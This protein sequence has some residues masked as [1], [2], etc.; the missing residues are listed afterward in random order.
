M[1]P[2]T[3]KTKICELKQAQN[4]KELGKIFQHWDFC[5]QKKKLD[6]DSFCNFF[7]YKIFTAFQIGSFWFFD[8]NIVF[9]K[10]KIQAKFNKI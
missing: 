10:N 3:I 6:R 8:L 1:T 9:F 7:W 4:L 2:K 5:Q